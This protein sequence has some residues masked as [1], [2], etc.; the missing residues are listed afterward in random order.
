MPAPRLLKAGGQRSTRYVFR[1]PLRGS[2][3]DLPLFAVD[4]EGRAHELPSLSLAEPAGSLLPLDRTAWP[5][6]AESL[7]G[8]WEG[9]PYPIHAMRPS[10]YMGRLLARAAH[11]DLG[12]AADPND[13]SDDDIVWV[14]SRRG[15][16]VSGNLILGSAAYNRWLREKVS[17]P[18]PL[19][20]QAQPATYAEMAAQALV[21]AGGGSSAGGEFPKFAALREHSDS[22]T[23]HV[24]VKFSGGSGSLSEQRWGDLLVCEHLAL[25]AAATLPGIVT[26]RSRILRHAGRTFLETERFDRIG[27]NGR[28]AMCGLDAIDPAFIG[29]N[30]SAWPHLAS[31]LHELGLIDTSAAEAIEVL[32]WYGRLIANSDMHTG[33]LSFYVDRTLRLAPVYDMLPMAYAPLPGGE[34]PPHTFDPAL[35]L[36][37]QRPTWLRAAGAALHFWNVA[38]NDARISERFRAICAANAAHVERLPELV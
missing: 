37:G 13:W 28:L 19:P 34:V 33:N 21:A 16:D 17:P 32:W 2:F 8:W 31:R 9:L 36:P 7:D 38:R 35:P 14:L 23:P 25:E 29:S 11:S 3:D 18:T 30:E 26:A 15:S 22:G 27:M 12:V 24:L 5:V 10:G 1:R 4:R 6:P 20:A